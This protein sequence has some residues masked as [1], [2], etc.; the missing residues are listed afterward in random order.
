MA[1]SSMVA[2][3][4]KAREPVCAFFQLLSMAIPFFWEPGKLP[5]DECVEWVD[6]P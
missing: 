1:F 2:L 3:T 4:P 5:S 6:L